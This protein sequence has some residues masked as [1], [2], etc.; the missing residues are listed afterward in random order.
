MS[1]ILGSTQILAGIGSIVLLWFTLHFFSRRNVGKPVTNIGF[2]VVPAFFCG[3]LEAACWSC[4]D[5]GRCNDRPHLATA[6]ASASP[7][8]GCR[9]SERA[10]M[11]LVTL[12]VHRSHHHRGGL[13]GRRFGR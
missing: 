4:A 7:R 6:G 8:K 9:R 12:G 5:S 3:S 10:A 1:F 11:A 13:V 2:A